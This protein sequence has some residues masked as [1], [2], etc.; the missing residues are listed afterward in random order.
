MRQQEW[1]WQR[2][3]SLGLTGDLR[4]EEREQGISRSWVPVRMQVVS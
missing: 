4:H 3:K 2:K 1:M